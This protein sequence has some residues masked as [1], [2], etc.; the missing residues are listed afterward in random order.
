MTLLWTAAEIAQATG[1]TVHGEFSASGVTFDS[2]EV[3]PGDLFVAMPGSVTDGH[4]FVPGA[5][6]A[7]AAGDDHVLDDQRRHGGALAG[8]HVAVGRV[9]DLLAA[10]GVQGDDVRVE[11]GHE[12]HPLR[13]RDTAVDV[14]AAQ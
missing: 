12:D 7:G 10:L 1:G 9:P 5:F 8:P 13:D 2:R 4:R 6:A 14:A 3:E 11:G